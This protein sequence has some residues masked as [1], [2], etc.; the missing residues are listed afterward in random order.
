MSDLRLII[1][2]V[3][4]TLVDSQV[5]I[6]DAFSFAYTRA[7]LPAPD[8]AEAL[9]YVGM[10]LEKIFPALSPELDSPTHAALVQG[11]R[12]AYFH[13][14]QERG[15]RASSPFF[16]GAR[17][18]LDLFHAQDWTLLGVATG[19]S[20]R[21]LDKLIAGY[22]LEGYFIS[23]QT[24][25]DHPSKPSPS[26]IHAILAETGV[27]AARAVMIGDTSFDMDMARAA[28]ICSI[29]VSWGY[30]AADTLVC[31]RLIDDFAALPDTVDQLIGPAT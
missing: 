1:F 17:A 15:S 9:S 5:M 6:Y 24:A 18:A 3:D 11:Y 30:H 7:G 4:G 29:G 27:P 14:R 21:G 2:D 28:G 12:D 25:D 26:M 10:S 19:K 16:P 8:R 31:D 13:I 20:T 22:G 23:R